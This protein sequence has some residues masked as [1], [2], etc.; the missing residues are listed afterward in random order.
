MP[1]EWDMVERRARQRDLV[2]ANGTRRGSRDHVVILDG[3]MST[4]E[5]GHET[6]AG[7]I[8]RLLR[9][10]PAAERP[11][12]FYEEGIQWSD[13]RAGLDVARGIGINRQIMRAYG[14]LASRYRPGDRI[15]LFG[16]SRGAFAVRSL[17]GVI[18]RIG[19]LRARCATERMVRQIYRHYRIDPHGAHA[20]ACAKRLC[21]PDAEIEMVG[22]FDT[23][24][25]LGWRLP[26]LW[27]WSERQHDFHSTHLG[28]RIRHGYHALALDETRQVYEPMLWDCPK[29]FAG[30]IEQVWFRGT[31]GDIGGQLMGA[32]AA[33][34]LANIPL[35]WM[36]ERAE[37]R[38]LALPEGWRAQFP[39]DPDAPSSGSWRGW[40]KA[41]LLRKR[42]MFGADP[43]EAL[44]PTA[45]AD[46]RGA[47][48]D[49][50][51]AGEV[52]V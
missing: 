5:P 28:H 36:L 48:L 50:P 7:L 20:R 34:P 12:L 10:L 51:Q 14:F 3:T 26:L 24:K 6:N 43:S 30:D 49:L 35:V 33:R 18:D 27:R 46:R 21:H 44:H 40:G 23:V 15:Y 1:A 22:V 2:S 9:D 47:A 45:L 52:G 13:W 19:L 32:E 31:H 39:C 8:Y 38:G 42:R 17:A 4:L 16:Y 37:L 29:G 11:S 41:F 25:A